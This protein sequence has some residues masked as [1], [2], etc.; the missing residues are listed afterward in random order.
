MVVRT[1]FQPVPVVV[2]VLTPAE[3]VAAAPTK[4]PA[5]VQTPDQR[6]DTP[7]IGAKTYDTKIRFHPD[8]TT[9]AEEAKLSK[10]DASRAAHLR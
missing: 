1:E 4:R 6:G 3:P 5:E 2:P 9:A 10:E 7:R 8:L